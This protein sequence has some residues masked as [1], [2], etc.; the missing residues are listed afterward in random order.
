MLVAH[1][2]FSF[3]FTI[4]LAEMDRRNTLAPPHSSKPT[5]SILQTPWLLMEGTVQYADH[6]VFNIRIMQQLGQKEGCETLK[7]VT[8]FNVTDL[9]KTFLPGR[10]FSGK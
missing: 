5:T 6:K 7:G 8:K 2:G 9:Y 10:E 4:L 1:N 3:D